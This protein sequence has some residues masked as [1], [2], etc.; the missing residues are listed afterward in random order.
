MMF[1]FAWNTISLSIERDAKSKD[2][3]S[4]VEGIMLE[5]RDALLATRLEVVNLSCKIN[6]CQELSMLVGLDC[7]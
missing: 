7:P 4:T 3:Q 2:S 6:I 5:I 1:F